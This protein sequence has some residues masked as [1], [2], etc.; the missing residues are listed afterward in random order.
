MVYNDAQLVNKAETIIVGHVKSGSLTV[1]QY[2]GDYISHAVLLVTT[3]LKGESARPEIPIIL[4]YGLLP[5]P[6][7]L[8]D[9]IASVDDILK[10]FPHAL[11]EKGP[12]L[13]FEDN[14][15]EGCSLISGDIYQNQIWLLRKNKV[16]VSQVPSGLPGTFRDVFV[17]GQGVWGPQDVQPLSKES[18]YKALL[19]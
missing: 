13:L 6:V 3:F 19:K 12:I 17:S 8:K 5:V 16:S 9:K 15:S 11:H 14:P 4:S 18:K 7:R 10:Q 2:P 1:T